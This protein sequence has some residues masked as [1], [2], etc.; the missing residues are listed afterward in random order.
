MA[1]TLDLRGVACPTNYVRVRLAL[2]P[3]AAGDEIEVLLAAG[4]PIA[5]VPRSVRDDGDEVLAVEREDD[6]FRVR[7]RKGEGADVGW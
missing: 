4:E 7:I 6:H 3:L 2:E 1:E 5:N